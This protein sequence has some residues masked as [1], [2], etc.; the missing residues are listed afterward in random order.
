V[1]VC[2][3]VCENS[4]LRRVLIPKR[5]TIPEVWRELHTEDLRSSYSLL[6]VV[7]VMKSMG[8]A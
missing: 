7:G 4:V 2:V 5:E 1:C 6:R 8:R 3:C